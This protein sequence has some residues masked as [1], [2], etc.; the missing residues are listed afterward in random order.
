MDCMERGLMRCLFF[1]LDIEKGSGPTIENLFGKCPSVEEVSVSN[2]WFK[3]A[4]TAADSAG[5]E[6]DRSRR[7]ES[8]SDDAH[9]T[10]HGKL[11][12]L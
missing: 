2:T 1:L 6:P 7:L 4:A 9:K 3:V 8:D 5:I 11:K 12:K 10:L